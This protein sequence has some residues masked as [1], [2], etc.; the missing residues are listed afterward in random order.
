MYCRDSY[1]PLQGSAE[2]L[3][4]WICAEQILSCY[5]INC[6]LLQMNSM[7]V[8]DWIK[9]RCLL[10]HLKEMIIC[11]LAIKKQ[12]PTLSK[13]VLLPCH[14]TSCPCVL[15]KLQETQWLHQDLI[16]FFFTSSFT[17]CKG[18]YWRWRFWWIWWIIGNLPKFPQPIF[19]NTV[20]YLI[21]C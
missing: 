16:N 4:S 20:K 3:A 10:P 18:K 13:L 1:L 6:V 2:V 14:I 9:T 11:H 8:V 19:V 5:L 17:S 21:P 15:K 7:I 12:Q